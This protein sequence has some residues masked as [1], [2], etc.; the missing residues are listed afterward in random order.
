MYAVE[1]CLRVLEEDKADVVH[2]DMT[3]GGMTVWD[4]SPV[5]LAGMRTSKV[6]KAKNPRILPRLR[7][8]VG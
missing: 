1:F 6:G 3:L 8:V 7:Q 4:F 5:E 2:L